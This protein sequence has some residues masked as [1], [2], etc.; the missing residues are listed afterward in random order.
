MAK[1]KSHSA[2]RDTRTG[3]FVK[4]ATYARSRSHGGKRYQKIKVAA[5]VQKRR[6]GVAQPPIPTT[7]SGGEAATS[8]TKRG[9]TINSLQEFYDFM[10]YDF[11]V[12]EYDTGI[13]YN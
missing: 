1:K 5:G 13:D 11:D 12:E 4:K 2:Y 3:R 6:A 8:T 7:A 9:S 10:D